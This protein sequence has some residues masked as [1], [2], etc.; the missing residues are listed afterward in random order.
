MF[1]GVW[2]EMNRKKK[3]EKTTVFRFVVERFF[4]R[5]GKLV[6]KRRRDSLSATAVKTIVRVAVRRPKAL[7][8][9]V[10]T[11]GWWC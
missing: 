8:D 4:Y 9:S 6:T 2:I 3:S 7:R 11:M 1:G 5:L 10:V